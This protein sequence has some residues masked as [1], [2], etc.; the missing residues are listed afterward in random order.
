[1]TWPVRDVTWRSAQQVPVCHCRW[2]SANGT[3]RWGTADAE[4]EVQ[5]VCAS[6]GDVYCNGFF[7]FFF[8][9]GGGGATPGYVSLQVL[10][11]IPGMCAITD[12]VHY[13]GYVCHYRWCSLYWVCVP[14]QMVFIMPGM[15]AITDGV[16]YTGYVCHYRWCSL[17]WV[18]VPLQMVFILPGM[19]A[20]TDGVHYTGY[21]CHYRWCSLH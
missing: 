6:I 14:L 3:P 21:V 13:T 15:C 17:H 19:C 10:F 20:I 1:M 12:G 16:H 9:R 18:C 2:R 11:I 8:W 5:L 7:F 4:I